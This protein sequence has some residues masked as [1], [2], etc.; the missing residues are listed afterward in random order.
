MATLTKLEQLQQLRKKLE[1]TR[2]QYSSGQLLYA[3]DLQ[4]KHRY[5]YGRKLY[6][7]QSFHVSGIIEGLEVVISSDKKSVDIK[8]GS[9]IDFEGHLILLKESKNFSNFGT[10]LATSG[11]LYLQFHEKETQ[12][13]TPPTLTKD[14]KVSFNRKTGD[15]QIIFVADSASSDTGKNVKLAQIK[16]DEQGNIF[17]D[18]KNNVREYSGFYFPN[19]NGSDLSLRSDSD[20]EKKNLAVLSGSLKI[21]ENLE[22]TGTITGN[23]DFKNITG[24]LTKLDIA[25]VPRTGTH[26]ITF[27]GLYVTGDFGEDSDGVEFRCTDGT[28][29]IGFGSNTIYAAGTNT[30][31][32]LNLKAKGDS[33]VNI[34]GSG[35][36]VKSI[37]FGL[38]QLRQ[39]INLWGTSYGI[40]IQPY[41]QYFRTEK[42]FA[43]YQGGSHDNEFNPSDPKVLMALN[44]EDCT[45]NSTNLQVKSI[46]F[47]SD[48]LRQMIN[49]WGTSYGIGIQPY[50]QYFR[51]EKNFAWYQGGSHDATELASGKDGKVLMTLSGNGDLK[52]SATIMDCMFTIKTGGRNDWSAMDHPVKKY[53]TEKLSNQPRGTYLRA[54]TDHPD[55]KGHFFQAWVDVDGLIR[56]THNRYN[57]AAT[58][59]NNNYH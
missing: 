14:G 51:T 59:E 52:V 41:T 56:V 42:N 12:S 5:L 22:V 47:A 50:T 7:H 55:W 29:G 53:F 57:T 54:I 28:K 8:G 43:W 30:N 25:S 39:M 11:E 21:S 31:Q 6:S 46:L 38:D 18:D 4:K 24:N 44:K 45:V 9:A 23:L 1:D 33:K 3:E 16:I 36:S 15:P 49:L 2:P 20:P 13:D 10:P 17:I 40:G 58:T 34:I 19:P 37:S 32:E 26:P 27:K 48:Q 35:L